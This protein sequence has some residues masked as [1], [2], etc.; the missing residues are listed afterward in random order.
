MKITPTTVELYEQFSSDLRAKLGIA[1]DVDLKEHFSA[2]GAVVAGM[3]KIMYLYAE[4]VQRNLYPDTADTEENGGQLN[5]LGML[6]LKRIPHQATPTFLNISVKGKSGS[7]LRTNLTFK[8]VK[9]GNIYIL[10][11]EYILSGTNDVVLVRSTS[12]GR[13]T[14]L[15][16]KSELN[17]TEPVLGVDKLCY[18][19]SIQK[20]GI[21]P[22]STEDYRKSIM[23]VMQLKP[24]GGAKTDYRLWSKDAQGV[25]NVYPYVKENFPGTI[26]IFVEA[27]PIDSTDN[28]GTPPAAILSNVLDVLKLDPDS[29]KPIWQRGR[30]PMQAKLEVIPINLVTV[31]VKIKGLSIQSNAIKNSIQNSI[32]SYLYDI[33]PFIDGGQLLRDRNDVLNVAR[34]SNIINNAISAEN[35]F[36]D[37]EMR[38]GGNLLNSYQFSLG[39]IPTLISVSYE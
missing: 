4:D 31:D 20:A 3:S 37:V 13:D 36:N 15:S 35:F 23:D 24:Q 21:N 14:I 5:R 26:L 18:V 2:L 12:A 9:S 39:K 11:S 22:E 34:L 8:D 32:K 10:D 17:I 33:R 29:S 6:Y 19:Q 1:S 7:T 28:K 30:R 16:I 38:V 27:N 25:R